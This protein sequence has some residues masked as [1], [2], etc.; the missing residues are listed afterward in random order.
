MDSLLNPKSLRVVE[1]NKEEWFSVDV[2]GSLCQLVLFRITFWL[3]QKALLTDVEAT[4]D[5]CMQLERSK[6]SLTVQMSTQNIH[7]EQVRIAEKL[8]VNR[9][10]V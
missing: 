7:Y 9:G 2:I 8:R 4:R 3:S 5:L 6:E 1:D 10:L